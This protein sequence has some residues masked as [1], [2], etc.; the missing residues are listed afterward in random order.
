MERGFSIVRSL[1]SHGSDT[2]DH[3]RGQ[4]LMNLAAALRQN[5]IKHFA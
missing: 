4:A 5:G 1:D 3:P 2:M